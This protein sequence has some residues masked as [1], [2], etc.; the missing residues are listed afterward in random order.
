M[1]R[2]VRRRYWTETTL[3][4]ISFV[5]LIITVISHDW[6]EL[7]FGIDPDR[8]NGTAEWAIVAGLAALTLLTAGAASHEWRRAT[9]PH[10]T[11]STTLRTE[12]T[13]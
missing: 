12:H 13:T 6:I 3:A 11:P 4:A 9:R 10:P 5:V 1:N 8:G 2:D 7:V